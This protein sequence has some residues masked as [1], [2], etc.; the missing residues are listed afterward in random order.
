MLKK[1]LSLHVRET[2][3]GKDAVFLSTYLPHLQDWPRIVLGFSLSRNLTQPLPAFYVISVRQTRDLPPASF[4]FHLT[5][6]TLAL[7]Y[8]LGTIN[9]RSGLPPIR[10]HPC[11]AHAQKEVIFVIEANKDDL[12]FIKITCR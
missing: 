7:G 5:M 10:L 1:K 11:R 9:P 3:P 4:R 2:S 8:A 12:F 6:D